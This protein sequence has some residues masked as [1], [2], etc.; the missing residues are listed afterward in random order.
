[1]CWVNGKWKYFNPRSPRGERQSGIHDHQSV[2]SFQ[3]TLPSRGATRL[4]NGTDPQ[5]VISTHAPL[6]GSD[7]GNETL[8]WGDKDFNPRSPRGERPSNF[9]SRFVTQEFQPTLPSRGATI[10]RRLKWHAHPIS[11]HAPLAGSD[12]RE[13]D[14]VTRF[15]EFQPTLPSRGAT[16]LLPLT[17]ILMSEFQPT[18]PSRGATSLSDEITTWAAKFQPT[19]PSRGATALPAICL[20]SWAY[21]NPR[22]PRGERPMSDETERADYL[23]FQPTLPSRGA[24]PS[25]DVFLEYEQISTHAPLAGSDQRSRGRLRSGPISTHAPLAGSD[26]PGSRGRCW[27]QFWISTHA[28]LAGSDRLKPAARQSFSISTHAPLAGSDS[29]YVQIHTRKFRKI[30]QKLLYLWKISHSYKT[31][32]YLRTEDPLLLGANLPYH[33]CTLPLRTATGSV[34]PPAGRMLCFQNAL[35]YSHNDSRDNKIA[36]CPFPDP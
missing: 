12:A 2:V 14:F 32:W 3:P 17:A 10:L 33:V 19:L 24:T 28:P 11:T 21:F 16:T 7:C 8:W 25:K 35:S 23:I 13:V 5:D 30:K 1:M 18:L 27:P 29:R 36:D 20:P 6:A 4:N 31:I 22:S 34:V 9:F 26:H 15:T